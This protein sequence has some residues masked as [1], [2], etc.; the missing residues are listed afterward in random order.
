MLLLCVAALVLTGILWTGCLLTLRDTVQ[1]DSQDLGGNAAAVGSDALLRQME[2]NLYKGAQSEAT[3]V[4]E[5]LERFAGFVRNSA[6]FAHQLYA[7]PEDYRPMEVLPPDAANAHT[8]TMQ[9]V[10]RSET[11]SQGEVAAEAGL[12]ANL[13][14]LWAPIMRENAGNIASIYL[15]AEN[16][17]MLN[18][19][20]RA[21]LAPSYWDYTASSWYRQAKEVGGDFYD[22]FLVDNTHL[23]VVVA[24]V[25]GKGAPAALFMVIG[26]TLIKDHTTPGKDLGEVFMEVNRLLC[27]GNAEEMF[28]TAF[29]GVLDLETGEFRFV[30]AGHE[31]PFLCRAGGQYEPYKIRA[32]FVL[33]GME[34]TRYKMGSVMLQ[35]GDKLFQYTDG[36]T[37]ATNEENELYGIRRLGEVLNRNAGAAPAAL[38]PAVKA[39]IDAFVGSSPQFD[40]ITMLSLEFKKKMRLSNPDE[41]TVAAVA[42]N[43]SRVTAF[44]E[45]RLEAMGCPVKTRALINVAVDE[46]FGNIAHY[47][48]DTVTGSATV[49][50][51]MEEAPAAACVTFMDHGKPYDPLAKPDPDITLSAEER[52]IGG[53]G[54]FMVKKTMDAVTYK[55]KD[56]QNIVTIKKNC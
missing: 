39:D 51:R 7:E 35:P 12:L 34:T 24:D 22:F 5:K 42:E 36:V 13:V 16:G 18:Y 45:E 49:R 33:A 6:F 1:R 30:N 9:L 44:V 54:I 2:Q 40:D 11:V 47:A 8:Y 3:V 15:C 28:I 32:G 27:E 38:I 31:T 4:D 17:L 37:E 43:I 23:A 29:E 52:P 26:K 10:L 19:D 56:G 14:H 21:D 53:L 46:L 25:S 41:L 20:E 50:V 48:Y 55:Y